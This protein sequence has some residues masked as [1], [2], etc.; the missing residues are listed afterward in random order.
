MYKKKAPIITI[1][2]ARNNIHLIKPSLS[3]QIDYYLKNLDRL[4]DQESYWFCERIE[5]FQ[6]GDRSRV[7]F[8]ER[9]YL[10]PLNRKIR[11]L[12]DRMSRLHI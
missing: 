4:T 10:T 2:A 1:G 11:E 9:T 7:D 5:A 3:S 12:A 8:I 6:K